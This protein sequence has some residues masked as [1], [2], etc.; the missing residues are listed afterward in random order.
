MIA[1]PCRAHPAQGG[2]WY[3]PDIAPAQ[4]GC[5]NYQS[6]TTPY[7]TCGF[8]KGDCVARGMYTRDS[9]SRKTG[10]FGGMQF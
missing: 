7:T 9:L 3:A 5:G 8:I 1:E 10:R 4:G 6:G 2:R